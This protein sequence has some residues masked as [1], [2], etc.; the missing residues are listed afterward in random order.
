MYTNLTTVQ[1]VAVVPFTS[2]YMDA[3]DGNITNVTVQAQCPFR[4]VSHVGLAVD[5]AVYDGIAGRTGPT[6]TIRLRC[7]AL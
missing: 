6:G 7:F 2:A 5:G 1:D 3:S 4:V